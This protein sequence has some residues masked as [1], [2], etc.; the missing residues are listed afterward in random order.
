MEKVS[1]ILN[2]SLTYSIYKVLEESNYDMI[3]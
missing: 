3:F 1:K 2:T